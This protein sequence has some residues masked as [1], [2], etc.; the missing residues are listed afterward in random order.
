MSEM[1]ADVANS[2]AKGAMPLA[3]M[4]VLEFS[5][6][7][8][9]PFGA[10][11]LADLGAECIRIQRAGTINPLGG[12][13]KFD[14]ILRGRPTISLDLKSE[15]ARDLV[16]DLVRKADVLIEGYRPGT[17]ERLGLG[18]DELCSLNE[19]L[20]YTRMSGWGQDGPLRRKAGHDINYLALSGG[21]FPIGP[22]D[23]PPTPPLNLVGNFGGGGMFLAM[24]V[25][26]A[27]QERQRSGMGQVLDVA[28]IDGISVLMTQLAGWMQMG[29]WFPG[30]G[31]N[32]LDGSAYFYRCYGTA[33]E[34]H[35]AVGAL[36]KP[37]HD[38]FIAG[39]G[40]RTEDFPDHLNPR[41]WPDRAA[42][43]ASIIKR[44][45]MRE[46][47]TRFADRDACVTPVLTLQEAATSTTND[48]RGSLI[49]GKAAFQPR[50]A[51]RFSRSPV[52]TPSETVEE[53]ADVRAVLER[54]GVA[55]TANL[56]A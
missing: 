13:A 32:L 54:W 19:R 46:W 30:R 38:A 49:S 50:P 20:V 52:R 56:P 2:E 4:R 42:S 15:G 53:A 29:Q 9:T 28:M 55:G 45:P 26:A 39:L 12:D 41:H 6:L 51:P 33:D 21:L 24:G 25:L 44:R 17:M 40:L 47:E 37:F 7:G 27:L 16:L 5:G 14:F 8:P 35:I 10:M 1:Q 48:A 31:G 3:G 22:F 34:R 43:I 23:G 36:E 11:L 18:P